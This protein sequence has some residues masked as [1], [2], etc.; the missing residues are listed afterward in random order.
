MAHRIAIAMLALA[1][2]G[3][4]AN[5]AHPALA[6]HA[7]PSAAAPSPSPDPAPTPSPRPTERVLDVKL[8]YQ[9]HNL[10]CEAAA[11]KMAL[12][13]EGITV[14]EMTLIGYMTLQSRPA[15]FDAKGHVVAWGDPAQGFVGNPNG[16]IQR[17]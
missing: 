5:T 15:T 9:E 6:S 2:A 11:L 3:C 1:L 10:T 16:N 7:S 17:Y 12:S 13:Y 14:D 8:H 4:S